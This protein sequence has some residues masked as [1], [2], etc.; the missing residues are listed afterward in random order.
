M[1][2]LSFVFTNSKQLLLL[3]TEAVGFFVSEKNR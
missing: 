2:G 1:A 3:S